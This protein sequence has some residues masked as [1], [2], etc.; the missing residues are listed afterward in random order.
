MWAALKDI[1]ECEES[2]GH[3]LASHIYGRKKSGQKFTSAIRIFLMLCYREA[4]T[5][6][7]HGRDEQG[8]KQR[9]PK[10]RPRTANPSPLSDPRSILTGSCGT[11]AETAIR[12][13]SP[14]RNYP[15]YVIFRFVR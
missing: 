5:K 11:L 7:G 8:R 2:S 10:R 13:E 4:A 9:S 3:A 12:P 1:A 15:M 6:P 14:A